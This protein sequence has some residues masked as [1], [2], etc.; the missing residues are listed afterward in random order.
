MTTQSTLRSRGMELLVAYQQN[1]SVRLRNQLV[2]LNAGLVRK[3]AH[4][5]SH[6]CAEPYEDLE[7]IGYMGLIRAI[8]RFNPSQ[9]CAFSSFAVPYI[10]GEMLH[11]L[12]DRSG[13]VKIPRRWQQLNKDG[14][15]V[16]EE[17]IET[18]GRQPTDNEIADR[19]NV[20]VNEWRE[21][22]IA[23]RNRLPLSLDA[24]VCHQIDSPMTL[25]DTIP[26]TQYQT[27][28]NLEEDRQ[29]LQK[30]L[31]QLE[32]KTRKAI[33]F[34][35][36]HELSRKEVAEQIGVSPMTVTRRIQR[37]VQQM[38]DYLQPQAMQTEP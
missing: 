29:Q 6:Q 12:R 35:F 3:I 19:L 22:K 28:Q 26:D 23:S 37:G 10:R 16:R 32:D 31:N 21:S 1:P 2:Q 15:K 13:T 36:L 30:A 9:G 25:G 7:Q 18:F 20:S 24:T 38:V 11:F 33:E 8:E 4:R 34:V 14:Q 27:L 5:V 17:F